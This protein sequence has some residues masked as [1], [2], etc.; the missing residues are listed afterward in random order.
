MINHF[1]CDFLSIFYFVSVSK[2]FSA[3]YKSY[4]TVRANFVLIPVLR[5]VVHIDH[6][7]F[8]NYSS[9]FSH[10]KTFHLMHQ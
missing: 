5:E 1:F 3:C 8:T 4:K 6:P 7:S 9:L 10:S 2:P